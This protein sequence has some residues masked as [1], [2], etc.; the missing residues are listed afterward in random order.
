MRPGNGAVASLKPRNKIEDAKVVS[1]LF[2]GFIPVSQSKAKH[3][4]IVSP[5]SG[6][7]PS[8]TSRFSF[9]VILVWLPTNLYVNASRSSRIGSPQACGGMWY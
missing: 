3:W 1:A 4:G 2:H 9:L 8:L 7:L 6:D 5:R